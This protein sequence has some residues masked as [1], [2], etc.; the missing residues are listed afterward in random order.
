MT[1]KTIQNA[2]ERTRRFD[3]ILIEHP[4]LGKIRDKILW[5]LADTGG[6]VAV[7]EARRAAA[8][9]RPVKNKELWVLPIVGPSGAMK[10]TSIGKV[11]DEINADESFPADDI[12]VLFV[13][14]RGVKNV[15]AFLTVILEH[16]GDAAKEVMPGSGPIDVQVV[17]RG[18]YHAART[19]RTLLLVIDEAHEM[20]RRRQDRQEH[21]DA[22]QDHG[23]RRH[24]QRGPGWH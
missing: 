3:E 17:A 4:R 10:S 6:A 22:A 13:T 14:M 8:R 24:L 2:M 5:L 19:K 15:R 20:L 21:G 1:N 12:P 7:N 9:G 11:I 23:Q 18:V 16:Y